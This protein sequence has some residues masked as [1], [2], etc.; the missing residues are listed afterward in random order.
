MRLY[1]VVAI[2]ER[3]VRKCYLTNAP[4]THREGCTI[5]RKQVPRKVIRYQLE[6][7]QPD[8]VAV[9]RLLYRFV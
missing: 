8:T 7:L 5:L 6:E 2:N 3:T 1:H 9:D 4:V